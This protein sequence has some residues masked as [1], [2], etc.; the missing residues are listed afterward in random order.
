MALRRR[1]CRKFLR[2]SDIDAKLTQLGCGV[3]EKPH[4][5]D[6]ILS[7]NAVRDHRGCLIARTRRQSAGM[8]RQI[9]AG[10]AEE[11]FILSTFPDFG[12]SV[13]EVY[14]M[15]NDREDYRVCVRWTGTGT[16]RGTACMANRPDDVRTGGDAQLYI[17]GRQIVEEWNLFNEFDV[18]AQLLRDESTTLLP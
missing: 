14:W 8:E 5:D 13:D 3:I 12:V 16:H 4:L 2:A 9:V 17:S 7:D 10:M 15:G 6:L 18:L 1:H 11:R